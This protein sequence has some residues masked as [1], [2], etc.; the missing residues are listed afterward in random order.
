MGLDL[1]KRKL[2]KYISGVTVRAII[3]A[4]IIIPFNN[5]WIYLTEIVRYAGHP[6]N[7]S[8]FYNAVFILL[9]LVGLNEVL[10]RVA[11]HWIF[12]QGELITIYIMINIASALAG[13][14]MIQVLIPG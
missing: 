10:K 13:H 3:I 9:L 5:Y 14:D 2:E 12:S 8:L 4:L 11:P 7:I 6:T 1:D